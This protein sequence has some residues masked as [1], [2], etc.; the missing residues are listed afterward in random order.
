MVFQSTSIDYFDVGT[1]FE[2]LVYGLENLKNGKHLTQRHLKAFRDIREMVE[3]E[4]P[5]EIFSKYGNS[6]KDK[7]VSPLE[8]NDKLIK[9]LNDKDLRGFDQTELTYSVMAFKHLANFYT[10]KAQ[11]VRVD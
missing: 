9:L 5:K 6:L 11:G 8:F 2:N 3:E 10:L 1:A 7:K 4:F